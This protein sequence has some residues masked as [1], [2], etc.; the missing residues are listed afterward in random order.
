MRD[1]LC[2]RLGILGTFGLVIYLSVTLKAGGSSRVVDTDLIDTKVS[3]CEDF[4]QYSCGQW[5]QKTDIPADR[6]RIYRFSEIDINT[7]N[8]LK[9]ILEK[10]ASGKFAPKQKYAAKMGAYYQSCSDEKN[11]SLAGKAGLK[12]LLNRIEN[13]RKETCAH[14]TVT[15]A[16]LVAEFHL[17]NI[18]ALFNFIVDQ[19]PGDARQVIPQVDQGGIGLP[20]KGYY[21]DDSAEMKKNRT[22]YL[23]HVAKMLKLSG[24]S[25][26]SAKKDAETVFAFE[27]AL[28]ESSL[29]PID[30]RDP[31]VLY[32]KMTLKDLQLLAPQFDWAVY[33]SQLG[34]KDSVAVNVAVP[35]FIKTMALLTYQGSIEALTKYLQWQV[36]HAVAEFSTSTLAKENFN[37]YGHFL[38][39]QKAQRPRW[40][41]CIASIDSQLGEA[42]GE[43]FVEVAFGP[44]AKSL[45]AAMMNQIQ[46]EV[47]QMFGKLD[48]M[49]QHTMDGAIKKLDTLVKKVGYPEPSRNYDSYSVTKNSW[50][51][52][53]MAG[54]RFESQRKIAKIGQPVDKGEWGMT[55]ST[56]N[57]YYNPLMNEIVFPAGI[58]QEPL[59]SIHADLAANY[60]A[61]GATV[62]HEITHGFDDEGRQFDE[63][64][65]L[66]DWWSEYSTTRFNEK[67]QCLERQYDQYTVANGVHV[68]G[69]LT[70]GE[71]IADLGGLKI[72]LNAFQKT[73]PTQPTGAEYQR[74]FVAY[75][76]S[77]CGKATPEYEK[78]IVQVDPHSPARFRVNGVVVNMPEFSQAFS[79]KEGQ[80]MSPKNRCQVW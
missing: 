34:I 8:I 20:E 37:F 36:I 65:N 80:A 3:P 42:L 2:K 21:L 61:T 31:K 50:F 72:A 46:E 33:F 69:A 66:K 30:R 57:A 73:S 41:E 15:L 63:N 51:A 27:K 40:K 54:N 59:F 70:L 43:A 23:S 32:H 62:G 47:R 35:E 18:P 39:G 6:S 48:W 10:Y 14:R 17:Q 56:N 68:K 75:A 7:E 9:T 60:G 11:S 78:N 29:S 64:G 49:D 52:N 19:D 13:L 25:G 22:K 38:N 4:F 5:L 79:C 74:F 16:E 26:S 71:N 1:W 58:L 53:V 45:G 76:Q 12:D 44:E 55:A 67:A 24:L 77:W 28:A